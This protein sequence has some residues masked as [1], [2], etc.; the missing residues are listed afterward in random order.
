MYDNRNRTQ[1]SQWGSPE[2][3][4]A[5][6]LIGQEWARFFPMRQFAQRRSQVRG[7]CGQSERQREKIGAI[8][9]HC[10]DTYDSR[11]VLTQQHGWPIMPCNHLT[12]HWPVMRP[13]ALAVPVMTCVRGLWLAFHGS[14]QIDEGTEPDWRAL[15]RWKLSKAR[16]L[17]VHK[18]FKIH[19]V[20]FIFGSLYIKTGKLSHLNWSNASWG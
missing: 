8:I 14:W 1:R 4:D 18:M 9:L 2:M 19:F 17:W 16:K 3:S 5:I 6:R 12:P 7:G 15:N 20:Y 11:V 13:H 10:D